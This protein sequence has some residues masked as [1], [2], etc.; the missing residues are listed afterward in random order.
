M[1]QA[2]SWILI[3]CLVF[4]SGCS[5]LSGKNADQADAGKEK[6]EV[7]QAATDVEGMLR[8]GPGKYAG[9]KYDEEKVKAELDK[10]PDNLTADEA[11]NYLIPLLAYEVF[12]AGDTVRR[13]SEFLLEYRSALPKHL[14]SAFRAPVPWAI[15]DDDG[16]ARPQA[17][18]H[19]IQRPVIIF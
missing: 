5:L 15:G 10:L 17:A 3:L 13:C 14:F 9:D 16:A 2:F 1:K 12:A 6:G 8:E 7:K 19:L 11:Y 4:S 18:D